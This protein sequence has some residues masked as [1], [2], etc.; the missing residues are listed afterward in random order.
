M[1]GLL[2]GAPAVRPAR[3]ARAV[4]LP[5]ARVQR[6]EHPLLDGVR[7]VRARPAR[8]APG[9][10]ARRARPPPGRGRAGAGECGRARE[11]AGDGEAIRST[12][13]SFPSGSFFFL[14]WRPTCRSNFVSRKNLL[15]F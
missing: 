2:A 15:F 10:R 11:A 9:A 13:G 7:A 14:I 12:A 4:R 6:G 3:R 8:R 5:R 1:L